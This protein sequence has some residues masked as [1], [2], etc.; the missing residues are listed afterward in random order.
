M[1][2]C[3][4]VRACTIVEAVRSIT[5]D[6]MYLASPW[7]YMWNKCDAGVVMLFLWREEFLCYQRRFKKVQCYTLQWVTC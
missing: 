6:G 3:V 4:H 5:D 2:A 7:G 1:C